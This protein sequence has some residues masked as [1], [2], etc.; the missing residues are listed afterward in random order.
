VFC[1]GASGVLGI[2][3]LAQRIVLSL[4][5]SF[6]TA[7]AFAPKPSTFVSRHK[8]P[9]TFSRSIANQM[10]SGP[11]Y[12]IPDQPA[13]FAK[14]KK[15]N[16]KRY[17]D[18]ESV[19][20]PSFLKG[21]RVAVTGANRGIGLCLAK[22]LVAAGGELVALVRSSSKEL[23]DLGPA[24]LVTGVDVTDDNMC[25]TLGD[26]IKGGPIDIVSRTQAV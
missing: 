7:L 9:L 24:D 22:E 14:A 21:K 3:V 5:T 19:Y 23:D 1:F 20:D 13:R 17:L 4:L 10:S 15:E 8:S 12:T 25:S 26:K 16:N 6:G 11:E 2:M 18:I